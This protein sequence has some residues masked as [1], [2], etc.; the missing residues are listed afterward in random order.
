MLLLSCRSG[1]KEVDA[2]VGDGNPGA[3]LDL[4]NQIRGQGDL[5]IDNFAGVEAVDVAVR[6]AQM[7]V[8]ATVGALDALDNALL[9]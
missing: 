2:I 9:G 6:V 1:T 8:E 5:N 3:G 7:A 4:L